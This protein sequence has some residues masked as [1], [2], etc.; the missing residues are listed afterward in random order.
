L[1]VSFF[2]IGDAIAAAALRRA[3]ISFS[4][5]DVVDDG[6]SFVNDEVAMVMVHILFW[7]SNFLESVWTEKL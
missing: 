5:P 4:L 1:E 3:W 6:E 2:G 7:L